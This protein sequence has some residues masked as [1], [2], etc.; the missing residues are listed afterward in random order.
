MTKLTM[1]GN[2][3]QTG[4]QSRVEMHKPTTWVGA[5][6]STRLYG[7]KWRQERER[8]LAKN[9]LCLHCLQERRTVAATEVDHKIPHRGDMNLFWDQSNWQGLCKSHHS[10]KTATENGGFGNSL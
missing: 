8:F 9:P 3:I 10:K 2:R 1:L 7:Y 4:I 5:E 6:R